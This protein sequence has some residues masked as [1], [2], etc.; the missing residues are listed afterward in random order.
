MTSEAYRGVVYGGKVILRDES[1]PLTD[2]TEVV[3]TP[4][5]GVTGSPAAVIAALESSPPVPSEW[6]DELEHLI[7]QGRRP[8]T[9]RDPFA[10]ESG[11]PESV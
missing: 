7:A 2:G 6:V 11:R 5:T 3:V 8:P 10:D 4:L 1:T 9:H